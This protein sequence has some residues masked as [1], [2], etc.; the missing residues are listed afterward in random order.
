MQLNRT[1]MW[2]TNNLITRNRLSLVLLFLM[3]IRVVP[4]GLLHYHNNYFA[5]FEALS[6]IADLPPEEVALDIENPACSFHEFLTLI[7]NGFITE[8]ESKILNSKDPNTGSTV[9]FDS[10]AKHHLFEILNK[11]SPRL[12]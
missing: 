8:V 1:A 4:Y 9:L 11:G 5:N 10:V 3:V 7:S 12:V 6:I 2:H